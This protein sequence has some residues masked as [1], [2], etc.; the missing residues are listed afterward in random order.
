MLTIGAVQITGGVIF[1]PAP[2]GPDANLGITYTNRS[3]SFTSSGWPSNLS[4]AT[5]G[6]HSS[7]FIVSS[8]SSRQVAIST[9]QGNTWTYNANTGVNSFTPSR[10]LSVGSTVYLLGGNVAKSTDNG[11]TW[12]N[13]GSMSAALGTAR[14]AATDGSKIVLAGITSGGTQLATGYS[15]NGTT[16]IAG[17]IPSGVSGAL[18]GCAYGNNIY[19]AVGQ[20]S[21]RCYT[22]PDGINWTY[23]DNLRLAVGDRQMN[24][25]VYGNGKFVAVG[26]SNKIASSTNGTTW[27]AE[28]GSSD[29]GN[30]TDINKVIY[31]DNKFVAFG[32]NGKVQTNTNNGGWINQTGLTSAGWAVGIGSPSPASSNTT[33][34]IG[35]GV[36]VS[37]G[38]PIA[39]MFTS[40]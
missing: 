15:L 35:G 17:N 11:V 13:S 7:T 5:A 33:I 39:R 8:S 21:S 26:Q 37:N 27:V 6:Y 12:T 1:S 32:P 34:I 20:P 24:D 3:S 18:N 9:D 10:I 14:G 29:Y 2:T 25:I 36:Y 4:V 19:V 28:T 40:L 23:T 31:V 38:I 30:T 16:W 22:S